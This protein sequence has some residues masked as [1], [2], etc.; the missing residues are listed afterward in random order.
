MD[1]CSISYRPIKDLVDGNIATFFHSWWSSLVEMPHYLVVDLGEKSALLNSVRPI[2]T[3]RTIVH[4]KRSTYIQ[5]IVIIRR[6]VWWRRE[7]WWQHSGYLTGRHPQGNDLN[8]TSRRSERSVQLR[9]NSAVKTF[10]LSLVRS[11]RDHEGHSLFCF[12]R[13]G[14]L[15]M[16]NGRTWIKKKNEE[17]YTAFL[18]IIVAAMPIYGMLWRWRLFNPQFNR[19][20]RDSWFQEWVR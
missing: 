10:P 13:T 18:S 1:E 17:I 14:N 7:N 19:W 11:D 15:S 9:G 16:F 6:M 5:V 2:P 20:K 4:G 8:R 12:R 3:V